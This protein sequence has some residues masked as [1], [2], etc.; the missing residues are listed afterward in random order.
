M[1]L[2]ISFLLVRFLPG[3]SKTYAVNAVQRKIRDKKQDENKRLLPPEKDYIVVETRV[4]ALIKI[5]ALIV[6]HEF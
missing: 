1:A 6:I 4:E 3:L 2:K 5:E